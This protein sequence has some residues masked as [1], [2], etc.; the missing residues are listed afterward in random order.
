MKSHRQNLT[1]QINTFSSLKETRNTP[2]LHRCHQESTEEETFQR[3]EENIYVI[4]QSLW[5]VEDEKYLLLQ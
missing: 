1:C 5:S 2:Q 3:Q 4:Q